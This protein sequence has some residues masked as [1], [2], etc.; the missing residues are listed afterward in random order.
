MKHHDDEKLSSPMTV[1]GM[2]NG[3]IGGLILILPVYALQAGYILTLIVIFA[4]GIF[5]YYSCYLCII[6]MGPEID[7][8]YAILRH[9]NGARWAKVFYDLCVWLNLI[10]LALLYFE[11]IMIQWQGLIPPHEVTFVNP[12]VNAF[13]LL[14]LI[15]L[16]K[17][18]ELGASIMAYG[19][20]SIVCYV[21]FLIWVA[22]TYNQGNDSV[23]YKPFGTGATTL[24]AAMGQAFSIQSF[25]I[26]VLKKNPN[27]KKYAF[28][29]LLAYIAGGLAYYYIA[30]MGSVGTIAVI[31][32]FGIEPTR[33]SRAVSRPLKATSEEA[34][35]KSTSWKLSTWFTS[36]RSSQS[37]LSSASA[38][39][40]MQ[41]ENLPYF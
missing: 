23:E 1:I 4:T 35:G 10:L 26:P 21:L 30:Y 25:F 22:A 5:S 18:L 41:A 16:L 6:H 12:L 34:P 33:A 14:G 17:Y 27:E 36:T 2:V 28:Y 7:L 39:R 24:A 29:T 15:F 11:L 20:I 40:L 13:V 3:M 37:S 9:F 32:A 38:F 19:I 8:D 31:Q